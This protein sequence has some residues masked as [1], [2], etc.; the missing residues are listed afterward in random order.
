LLVVKQRP[1]LEIA[2][3]KLLWIEFRLN[4][5]HLLC[6]VCYRPPIDDLGSINT[7]L[8]DFQKSLHAICDLP[9]D[10]NLII[11]GDFNAHYNINYPQESTDVGIRLH[12]FLDGNNLT[13]LIT[14]RTRV[15]SHNASILDL[16]I[17]SCPTFLQKW[18]L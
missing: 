17:T 13:Q 12:S 6:C 14:E 18:E 9:R 7:F 15:T 11:V 5:N 2:G 1:D 16:V 4:Q 8:N 10:F 3:L